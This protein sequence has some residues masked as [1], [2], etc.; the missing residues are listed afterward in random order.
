MIEV[1]ERARFL[2]CKMVYLCVTNDRSGREG[3]F[4]FRFLSCKMV[5][6]CVTNDRS[7]RFLVQVS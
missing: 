7:G 5:Y 2:S 6:L 1:G 3:G 4:L